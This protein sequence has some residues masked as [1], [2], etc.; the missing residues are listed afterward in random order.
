MSRKTNRDYA[1]PDA[2]ETVSLA[3]ELVL[4]EL[5]VSELEVSDL[6]PDVPEDPFESPLDG[7]SPLSLVSFDVLLEELGEVEELVPDD[8]ASFL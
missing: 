1:S 8:L 3:A 2:V 6:T 4:F 7:E 5:E